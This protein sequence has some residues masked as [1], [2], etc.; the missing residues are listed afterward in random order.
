MA[1]QHPQQT[2]GQYKIRRLSWNH[3]GEVYGITMPRGIA[4]KFKD[5]KFTIELTKDSII[6]KS[7]IDLA[8]LKEEIGRYPIQKI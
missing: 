2:Y 3:I 8:Q 4:D 5:V 1:N 6:L 7:G